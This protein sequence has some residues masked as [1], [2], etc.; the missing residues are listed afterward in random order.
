MLDRVQQ[1]IDEFILNRSTL[2]ASAFHEGLASLDAVHMV[3]QADHRIFSEVFRAFSL[4]PP[5]A[6]SVPGDDGVRI[7]PSLFL[8]A[9]EERG[10]LS[11]GEVRAM[12][13]LD[14]LASGIVGDATRPL[15]VEDV[16]ALERALDHDPS[17]ECQERSERLPPDDEPGAVAR[18]FR[19]VARRLFLA[20]LVVRT[21]VAVELGLRELG[22]SAFFAL[23]PAE[24]ANAW[25]RQRGD[26]DE[27]ASA[28]RELGLP[29]FA[30]LSEP[31]QREALEGWTST[32]GTPGW[33]GYRHDAQPPGR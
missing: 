23:S 7:G 24:E 3:L 8:P 29:V 2:R 4:A 22:L 32:L 30:G 5:A 17:Q 15:T 33:P 18:R 12:W 13:G 26:L 10:D 9:L 28:L 31:D 11:A 19:E 27:L 6:P 16:D 1:A 20:A 21:R 25:D 14:E